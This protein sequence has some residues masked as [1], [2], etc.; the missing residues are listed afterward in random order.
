MKFTGDYYD[1]PIGIKA[2]ILRMRNN[3]EHEGQFERNSNLMHGVIKSI[4][5]AN[6]SRPQYT[7]WYRGIKLHEISESEFKDWY[8]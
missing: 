1:D 5:Q 3:D 7:R 2:G 4:T 6:M 8:L